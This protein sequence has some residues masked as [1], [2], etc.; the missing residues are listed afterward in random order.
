MRQ[1]VVMDAAATRREISNQHRQTAST[2]RIVMKTKT[3]A[4]E[5]AVV[6]EDAV[7]T[8]E[9]KWVEEDV[10]ERGR[11]RGTTSH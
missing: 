1:H 10:V 4:A 2:A 11:G 8:G 6:E 7:E 3:M 5:S 9:M